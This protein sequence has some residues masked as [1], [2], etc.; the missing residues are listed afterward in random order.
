MLHLQFTHMPCAGLN[1]LEAILQALLVADVLSHPLLQQAIIKCLQQIAFHCYPI[2]FPGEWFQV[3]TVE[4]G[5]PDNTPGMIALQDGCN[6]GV[7]PCSAMTAHIA[8]L[9]EPGCYPVI[10]QTLIA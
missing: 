2:P 10:P 4:L 7:L 8:H 9:V 1:T 5:W 6:G 3:M